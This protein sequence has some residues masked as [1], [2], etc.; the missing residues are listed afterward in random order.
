MSSRLTGQQ[1]YTIRAVSIQTE[2]TMRA[3]FLSTANRPVN[4][5]PSEDGGFIVTAARGPT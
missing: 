3:R 4:N 2:K 5:T 1:P